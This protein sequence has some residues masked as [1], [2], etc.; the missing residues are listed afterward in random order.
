[1]VEAERN[2]GKQ[3]R[4]ARNPDVQLESGGHNEDTIN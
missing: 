2:A 3:V 4:S 1:M